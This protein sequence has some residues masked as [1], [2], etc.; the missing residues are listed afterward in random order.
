MAFSVDQASLGTI[1]T[2][3]NATSFTLT[4]TNAVASG[5]LI[6]V[7][8]GWFVNSVGALNVTV[9]GG[10]LTWTTAVQV[11]TA[12]GADGCA[13]G[14]AL[15]PAGLASST[16]LT[17]ASG[18]T[19]G[20]GEPIAGALSFLGSAASSPQDGTSS[21]AAAAGNPWSGNAIST[22]GSSDLVVG[23]AWGDG[24]AGN[25]TDTPTS[26]WSAGPILANT[27]GSGGV[28]AIVY[29]MNVAAGSYSPGGTWATNVP[30]STATVGTGF[31][32]AVAAAS[33]F[34]PHRMPLG[35]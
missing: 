4:T 35:V 10:G 30:S 6:V 5:G 21:K 29:Q 9:S 31:L 28:T 11:G 25:T 1:F 12:S 14:W 3:T 24:N 19:N 8:V 33:T 16:V 2:S 27:T 23:V 20:F 22:S 34:S 18:Q 17:I 32:A 26:P 7:G 15:A 13:L